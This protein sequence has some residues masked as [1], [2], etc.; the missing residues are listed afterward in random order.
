MHER[1]PLNMTTVP[2]EVE[3]LVEGKPLLAHLAT[4]VDNHPHVAPVWYHYE[5]GTI[6]ATTAGKKVHNVRQN[7]HV[8]VSIQ[9]DDDGHPEWMVLFEGRA[10]VIED[11]EGI[12]EGTRNVYEHYLGDDPDEWDDF[13]QKQITDPDDE[14]FVIE[15]D[16]ESV[17]SK[18][19]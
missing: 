10:T 14:R 15:V 11:T 19:Y 1:K 16:V 3:A 8:A 17:A 7:P 9:K 18:R 12:K 5:D 2:S 4:A 13:W 6:Q